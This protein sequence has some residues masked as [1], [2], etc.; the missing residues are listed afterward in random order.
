MINK[1]TVEGFKSLLNNSIDLNRLNI[2]TGL[3]SS[4]KSSIIQ[5]L[6]ILS[7]FSQHI[8]NPL[9]EGHGDA[10]ELQN[11]NIKSPFKITAE[12]GENTYKICYSPEDKDKILDNENNFPEL[13]F[14][15][16]ER[17]GSLVSIP[18]S[19]DDLLGSKGENVIKCI[20]LHGEDI[21]NELL[22]H[23]NSEGDTFL[24]NLRGWLETITPGVKFDYK[25]IREADISYSLFNGHR[26]KNV[27][28]GL[29][30]T[31]PIIV[32]LFLGS[33]KKENTI[34]I[35]ENPEAHLHPKGQTE[36]GKLIAATAHSGCQVIV[37]THSDHLFDGVRI[38]AKQH[39]GFDSMVNINWCELNSNSTTVIQSPKL[40]RNGKL[41]FWPSGFFDQFE[42]NSYEL[43]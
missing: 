13:I 16:A 17:Y 42:I 22:F 19:S 11:P 21:L 32:A 20:E 33:L 27:G 7:R 6:R 14:I 34:V 31:L 24:F 1:L 30:Y 40:D 26:A 8:E 12:Y 9:I 43:I 18:M 4:G 25:T 15:S 23:E 5:S 29:S 3:N 36:M 10:K 41:S 38:Y 28:F 39:K 37:E 35:L 2:L